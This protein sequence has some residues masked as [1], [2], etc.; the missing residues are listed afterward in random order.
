MVD[1]YLAVKNLLDAIRGNAMRVDEVFCDQN[2]PA[3][4]ALLRHMQS[5]YEHLERVDDG[6]LPRSSFTNLGRHIHFGQHTDFFDILN[7]DLPEL[8][9]GADTILAAWGTQLPTGDVRSFEQ[10][11]HPRILGTS[12]PQLLDGHFRDAVLNSIISVFDFIRERTGIS[13]D[14]DRLIGHVMSPEKPLLVLSELSTESGLNDQKGFM[15][16]L[17][18]AFQGIRNP[19]AH[20]LSHDLDKTQAAQYLVFASLLAKRI[21][22]AKLPKHGNVTPIVG[23]IVK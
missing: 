17:K 12:Y 20:S 4:A 16:I 5:D 14:G 22:D 7:R 11:L 21:E 2:E 13:E 8:Q 6:R 19:R 1:W 23:G 3:I 9:K 15:Q 10:L 18:G